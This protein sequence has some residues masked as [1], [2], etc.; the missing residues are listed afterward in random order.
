MGTGEIQR[1]GKVSEK[2]RQTVREWGREAGQRE[3]EEPSFCALLLQFLKNSPT[4]ATC[5]P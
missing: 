1:M 4:P 2:E 5:S 3:R